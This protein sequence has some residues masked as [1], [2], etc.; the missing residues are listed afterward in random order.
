MSPTRLIIAFGLALSTPELLTP[1]EVQIPITAAR[2]IDLGGLVTRLAEATGR[3]L[4][5]PEASVSLPI[6]GAAG[7]LTRRMLAESLGPSARIALR[8]DALVITLDPTLRDPT[9]GADWQRR[10]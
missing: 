8:G 2:E 10:L 7:A 3:T 5:R 4:P 6:G 9:R 1:L